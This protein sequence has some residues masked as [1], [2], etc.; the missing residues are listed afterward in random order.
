MTSKPQTRRCYVY[1]TLPGQTKAVTAGRYEH[2]MTPAGVAI[3]RFV[4]GRS[5]LSRN[6][7]VEIDPLELKLAPRLYETPLLKGIFG[8]LRD[9][10]PDYWGRLVIQR[11]L[12]RDDLGEM[13]YLLNS[14]DDRAGAEASRGHH[15]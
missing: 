13:D 9:A 3:G 7:A 14:A 12:R 4:Y 2:E 11:A 5:Y 1:M 15:R 8:G 10:S 6:D